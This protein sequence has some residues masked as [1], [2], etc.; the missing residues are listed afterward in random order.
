MRP[1]RHSIKG[2]RLMD[3][4]AK[5]GTGGQPKRSVRELALEFGIDPRRLGRLLSADPGAPVSILETGTNTR[6]YDPATV[7]QW[8]NKKQQITATGEP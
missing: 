7:R 8:W 2:A 3:A 4:L 1:R 5:P 6:W